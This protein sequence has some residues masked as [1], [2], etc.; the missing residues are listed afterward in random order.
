MK[1]LVLTISLFLITCVLNAQKPQFKALIFTKTEEYRHNSILE[2]VKA[3]KDLSEA[4]L[5]DLVWTEDANIFNTESLQ[6]FDVIV[7]LNTTGEILNEN[8]K[9]AFKKFILGGNGFMGVHAASDTHNNWPWFVGLVGGSFQ[10]HPYI[11]SA[12]I[13]N[14][15]RQHPS[16]FH[17]DEK[18]LWTDEWYVF[19]NL[20]DN[21]KI[22]LSVDENSYD[23]DFSWEATTGMG[24]NHPIAWYQ[25]YDGGRSF[26]TALGHMEDSFKNPVFIQHLYGGLYWAA[27]GNQK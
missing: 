21:I 4:H 8:Q 6:Q 15:N 1:L 12:V 16:T 7:F 5:F 2:G 10:S 25:Y 20:S 19:K 26:Y 27:R 9:M 23:P 14:T 18:W 3:F 11:Q 13:H 24:E 17:L 22:L